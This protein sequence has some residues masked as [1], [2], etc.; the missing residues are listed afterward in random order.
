MNNYY[1][2]LNR[3]CGLV[4]FT[5]CCRFQMTFA[6]FTFKWSEYG[7]YSIGSCMLSSFIGNADSIDEY[8]FAHVQ[9]QTGIQEAV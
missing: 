1:N 8:S 7:N 6:Q 3:F 2:F 4:V 9:G 5:A